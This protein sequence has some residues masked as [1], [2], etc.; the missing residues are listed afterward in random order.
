MRTAL[1]SCRS[2]SQLTLLEPATVQA[3][4]DGRQPAALTLPVLTE[5]F[6]VTWGEQRAILAGA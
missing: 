5:P 6:P 3:I 2:R 4:I 1:R